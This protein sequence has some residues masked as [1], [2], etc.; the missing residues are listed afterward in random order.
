MIKMAFYT[1]E[2]EQIKH[3]FQ[4]IYLKFTI[5]ATGS[6][7]HQTVKIFYQFLQLLLLSQEVR[8]TLS[9][10][11]TPLGYLLQSLTKKLP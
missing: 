6:K 5:Q 9:L 8:L 10:Q 11:I 7:K 3:L 2:V 1:L 4:I